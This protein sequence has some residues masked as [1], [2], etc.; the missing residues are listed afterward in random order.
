[1]NLLRAA[2]TSAAT[3]AALALCSCAQP[4][5]AP[6]V[7]EPTSS[8]SRIRVVNESTDALRDLHL[9]FPR[10]DV[11]VGDVAAGAA[12]DYVEVTHGVYNYSAFRFLRGGEYVVQPVIDFVGETPLP[13]DDYTYVL[14]VDPDRGDRLA[15]LTV[16]RA[17]TATADAHDSG[18]NWVRWVAMGPRV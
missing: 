9:L 14:G 1:M 5:I 17:G 10:E 4:G 2:R 13:I 11:A 8:T 16:L 3:L 12:S 6:P 18:A 7:S 15:L